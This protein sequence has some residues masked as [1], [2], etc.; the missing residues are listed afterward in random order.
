MEFEGQYLYGE[1][2]GFG[3]EYFINGKLLFEGEYKGRK[4]WTG[5][6]Y[7]SQQNVAFE[8]KDGNGYMKYYEPYCGKLSCEGNYKN[9]EL[10][11]PIK[12]YNIY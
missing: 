7:D 10:I 3:K 2:I 1:R 4:K 9:G 6:G 5:K 11:E 8:I 12:R